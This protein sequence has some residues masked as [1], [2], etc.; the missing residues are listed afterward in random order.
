MCHKISLLFCEPG[1]VMQCTNA[2]PCKYTSSERNSLLILM[3]ICNLSLILGVTFRMIWFCLCRLECL[4]L[5]F[6]EHF[7]FY[8]CR[9]FV[10]LFVLFCFVFFPKCVYMHVHLFSLWHHL[11]MV[12]LF[13]V[14]RTKFIMSLLYEIF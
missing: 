3:D 6:A 10:C 2:G 13:L 14:G 12:L 8:L 1:V 11:K 5:L 7:H 4:R 9:I